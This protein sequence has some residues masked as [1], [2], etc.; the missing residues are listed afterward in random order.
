[1]SL[2]ALYKVSDLYSV[3]F[4]TY[5][6][7]YNIPGFYFG[8]SDEL[9]AVYLTAGTVIHYGLLDFNIGLADSHLMSGN[10]RKQTVGM[11][12]LSFHL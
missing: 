10:W 1:V 7:R 6:I 12:S 9:N 4:G 2:S 3:S 8:T 11:V 5:F